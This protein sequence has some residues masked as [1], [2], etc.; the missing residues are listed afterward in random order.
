MRGHR[1]C[2]FWYG[3]VLTAAV[4]A[5][6][7]A[8]VSGAAPAIADMATITGTVVD[9]S[10]T[11]QANVAV[12]VLDPSTSSTVTST[13]TDA[14]GDFTV[15]VAP[16]TYNLRF[17]PPSGSG[18]QSYLATG[19]STDSPPLTVI[20]KPIAVVHINGTF[21]DSKGNVY[22]N[23]QNAQ[24]TFSSPL[25]PGSYVTADASGHY[26]VD[27][28]ADQNVAVSTFV[29]PQ[30]GP[31]MAFSLPVGTLDHDQTY[32]VTM[33]VSQLS[34]SVRDSNG[35]PITGGQFQFDYSSEN[36]LPG[37]P[38]GSA[39]AYTA[40]PPRLDANGNLSLLVPNGITLKNPV[41]RLDTGLVIPFTAPAV[42]GDQSVI[43]TAPPFVRV[44]G[45]FSD[46]K[47]NVYTNQQNAQLT[48][49]SPLNPGS[50]VTADAS[51]HY[52]VDLLADQNVA[53]STFVEPQVGPFMAF[54]L[55]V[56]TLDHDQTY[57][58]TMPVSQLS[59]S[60]RDSN[61]NPITGGQFQFDYSSENSLPGA[62]GGSA[63]AY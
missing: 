13:T 9:S 14:Q 3:L 33:P 24:L 31:F 28:L 6:S 61:G 26:S 21:S 5:T 25:N 41:I 56:G 34:V 40:T 48:F 42:N 51:G 36:S 2:R 59:V 16:G 27:L 53:V 11:A 62:P 23:Q 18:L 4:L 29:E 55:P 19:V 15:T 22:T 49:S 54:S 39:Y 17:T 57:N 35:N 38:G 43:V 10:G 37:A 50:Y 47:G 46:S 1:A 52:S 8:A 45:T 30:V 32:N 63:Y 44:Q 20:L 58:V 7:L 12:A 60:V